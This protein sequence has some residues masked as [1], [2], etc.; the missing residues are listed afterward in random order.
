MRSG[1][2]EGVTLADVQRDL[3]RYLD[4]HRETNQ[5]IL[6]WLFLAFGVSSLLLLLEAVAWIVNLA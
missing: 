2:V 3:A 5:R 6:F 1:R 4:G